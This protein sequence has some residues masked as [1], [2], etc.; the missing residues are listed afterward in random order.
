LDVERFGQSPIGSLVPISGIDGYGRE[1]D[2]F[3]YEPSPLPSKIDLSGDTWD[4]LAEAAAALGR[5]EGEG[6]RLPN[7]RTLARPSIRAEAI[8]S[9]ALEGTYTTLPQ[10]LQSGLF[11]DERSPDDVVEVLDY[12]RAAE[13]GFDLIAAGQPLSLNMIRRLHRQ[14][15]ASDRHCPADQKGNVRTRQNFIGPRP[16]SEI[17]DSYFVPPRPGDGLMQGLY[18]WENW[19]H[20]TGINRL[21]RISVGHYQFETLHPFFDGNGRLGRLIAILQLLHEGALS[22][23]LLNISPY[24]EDHR[25]AYQNHL[26]EVTVT[27]D[28]NAWVEFF[29]RGVRIQSESALTKIDHLLD[30]K[31]SMVLDLHSRRVRGVAIRIAEELIGFPFMTPAVAASR[32]DVSVQAATNALNTL[33][34]MGH[35]NKVKW[36]SNRLMYAA[37]PIL[38]VIYE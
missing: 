5:L 31:E 22:V 16:D 29:C 6:R 26:R 10:V 14:L 33:E 38:D 17:K 8:S 7:P 11:E 15:M 30:I 2:H 3:A 21:I 35:V 32:Y 25:D 24:L 4:A 23:P 34:R 9:S 36:L 20:K 37:Q 19:I 28:F 13:M 12:V 18:E 27:G 1:F